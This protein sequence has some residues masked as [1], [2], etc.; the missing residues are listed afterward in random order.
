[1]NGNNIIITKNG[2]AIA[3]VKAHEIQSGCQT[4]PIS[5]ATDGEWEH[6]MVGRKNWSVNVN[7]LVLAVSQLDGVLETGD[8]VTIVIKDR[9]ATKSVSG[10]AICIACKQSYSRGNIANGTFQFQ[11]TGP[12]SSGT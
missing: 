4:I 11:G 5:S 10:S 2:T 9:N 7:Y 1:M 8:V 12:L 3:A 6:S